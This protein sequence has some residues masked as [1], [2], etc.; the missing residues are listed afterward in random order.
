MKQQTQQHHR[1]RGL[2]LV[3]MLISLAITAMLL[4]ATMVA[5]DASFKAYASAAESASTQTSTR[6]VINRLLTMV[7]TSTAHGPLTL[8]SAQSIDAGATLNGNIITCN[9]IEMIDSKGRLVRI[10]YVEDEEQLYVRVDD[11]KDFSFGSTETYQPLLGGVT[12]AKFHVR[13]RF[14]NEGVIVLERGSVEL[15]VVPDEDNT[16]AIETAEQTQI[17]VVASTMPRRLDD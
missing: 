10:E 2:S 9:H 13:Y 1:Q 8:A 17:Q 7:R 16:L 4:T 15:T 11:N 5:T 3:E 14:D 6:M 12:K